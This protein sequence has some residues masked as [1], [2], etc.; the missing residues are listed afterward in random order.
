MKTNICLISSGFSN[1]QKSTPYKLNLDMLH[2]KDLY[3]TISSKG[4][5]SKGLN[6]TERWFEMDGHWWVYVWSKTYKV[7][8]L[9]YHQ[10]RNSEPLC[11][12]WTSF[13]LVRPVLNHHIY[14]LSKSQT[15]HGSSEAG[16]QYNKNYAIKFSKNS[17]HFKK[18]QQFSSRKS[19]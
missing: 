5:F 15:Y 3:G 8:K 19:Q 7:K 12:K 10:P 18:R 6:V 1:S 14:I 13:L 16:W 9:S 17:S 4:A 11:R 2:L